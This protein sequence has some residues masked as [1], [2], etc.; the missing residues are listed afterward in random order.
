[1]AEYASL[2]ELYADHGASMVDVGE[3]VIPAHFG[4]PERTHLAV[5]NG[6]GVSHRPFD[7]IEITGSD[8]IEYLDNAVSNRVPDTPG[9]G[10]YA[11]LLDPQGGIRVDLYV[12]V[13]ESHVKVLAPAGTGQSLAEE[14]E[15]TVF[16]QDVSIREATSDHVCFSVDGPKSTEKLSSIGLGDA[17]PDTPLHFAGGTLDDIPVTIVRGDAL[18]GETEYVLLCE[19]SEAPRVF[20]MCLTIGIG[21]VAYGEE[22]WRS[23]TL[24]A[25]TPLLEPDFTGMIPN[26]IGLRSALDFAKGCY[27]GQ[28][29]VSRVENRGQPSQRLIG[30]QPASVP[31][32]GA[33]VFDGDAAVGEIT[34]AVMSPSL[35]EAIAFALVPYDLEASALTV[36]VEGEEV[37]VARVDLPFVTGSEQSARIPRY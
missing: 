30:L 7:V 16:I 6:V 35:G 19:P 15:E 31:T 37:S 33:A 21:A 13:G 18:T 11:L 24:E 36:R 12:L 5:R 3:H 1:M 8:R 29:I 25:G 17:I 22:T 32:E 27:V 26:I 9:A 10:T 4:R 2:D 23:L 14:W 28:E 20:D 34:R